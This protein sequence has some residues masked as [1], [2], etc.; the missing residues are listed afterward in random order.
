MHTEYLHY[1][2]QYSQ[3]IDIGKCKAIK[4]NDFLKV[5]GQLPKSEIKIPYF[6][7]MNAICKEWLCRIK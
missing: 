3:A 5:T 7:S 1:Q 4:E 2:C 6:T